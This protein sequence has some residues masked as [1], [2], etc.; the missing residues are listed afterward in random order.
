MHHEITPTWVKHATFINSSFYSKTFHAQ[1]TSKRNMPITEGTSF[2][3]LYALLENS[4]ISVMRI[5]RCLFTG[6][7]LLLLTAYQRLVIS[8]QC[9][10][11]INIMGFLWVLLSGLEFHCASDHSKLFYKVNTRFSTNAVPWPMLVTV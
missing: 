8:C 4:F 5:Q 3:H 9:C 6:N 1:N 7:R 2:S 10:V 11:A